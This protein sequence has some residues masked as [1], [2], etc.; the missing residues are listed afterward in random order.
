MKI[1]EKRAMEMVAKIEKAM[2][3]ELSNYDRNISEAYFSQGYRE[4]ILDVL[5]EV[6]KLCN[7]RQV[8]E[9]LEELK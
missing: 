7:V 2:G 9:K 6:R 5:C 4:A 8:I 3:L 1:P